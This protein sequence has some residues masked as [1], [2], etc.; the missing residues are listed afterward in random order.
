VAQDERKVYGLSPEYANDVAEQV[1]EIN[2]TRTEGQQQLSDAQAKLK[3][4][5][6]NKLEAGRQILADAAQAVYQEQA[7]VQEPFANIAA[8]M[9]DPVSDAASI[10]GIIEGAANRYGVKPDEIPSAALRALP[11][12]AEATGP[13][14]LTHNELQMAQAINKTP[15]WQ[16]MSAVDIRNALPNLVY[17]PKQI[18]AILSVAR[19]EE[20]TPATGDVPFGDLTRIR[21]DL[22]GAAQSQRTV[23]LRPRYLKRR[24]K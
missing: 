17:A 14:S 10:H 16:N 24:T 18:D 2:A 21:E 1:K 20:A 15:K 7:R 6:K 5:G 11:S 22:Y 19:P 4:L 3:A 13:R 8:Q 12:E 23:Q 9:T